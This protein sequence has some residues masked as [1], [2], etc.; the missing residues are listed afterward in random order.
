MPIVIAGRNFGLSAIIAFLVLVA[1]FVL[2]LVGGVTP[3]AI[4]TMI[5][6]LALAYLIG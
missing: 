4:L 6:A 1:C 5:G 3:L 2:F